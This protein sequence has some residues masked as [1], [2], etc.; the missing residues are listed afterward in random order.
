MTGAI[1]SQNVNESSV[2]ILCFNSGCTPIQR[3]VFLQLNQQIIKNYVNL[4]LGLWIDM[5]EITLQTN[6]KLDTCHSN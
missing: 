5:L 4:I 6:H 3:F 1:Y 2:I